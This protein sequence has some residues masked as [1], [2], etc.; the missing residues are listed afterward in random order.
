MSN[1]TFVTVFRVLFSKKVAFRV[2]SS[3]PTNKLTT[4]YNVIQRKTVV[5]IPFHN[6]FIVGI[7]KGRK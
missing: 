6:F 3:R 4:K 5:L 1:S 7:V 2:K